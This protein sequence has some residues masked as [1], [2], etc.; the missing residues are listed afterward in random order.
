MS[1]NGRPPLSHYWTPGYWPIWLGIAFLRATCW[2]PY[3]TQIA[4]G[5]SIGRLAHRVAATRRAITRRNIEICFPGLDEKERNELALQHFESLGASLMEMALA[6][7][8]STE[9]L[10]SLVTV[11]GREHIHENTQDGHGVIMLSAHFTTVEITGRTVC[12]DTPPLDVVYR[13]F[14]NGLTTEFV[15]STRELYA[16]RT[17]D[18]NDIKSMVRSL[19]GGAMVWYA[20]DQSYNQKQ[21][22]LINFFGEPAMTNTATTTL[23]KLG[24]AK[25]LPYFTRRLPEGG[26]EV[27][28]LPPLDG[29]P[30][31]DPVADTQKYNDALE[32]YVRKCPEQYYW[33]H[34]KFKN[35]PAELPDA[36][37]NLDA[38]K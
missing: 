26:Y 38:L 23:A 18:K 19:R 22:A 10:D 12:V 24:R 29:V 32:A 14:R 34:R 5:K 21:S 25:V 31:D 30:S 8:A 17:I 1:A 7:W 16:R 35:R 6:R 13:K 27:R 9:K 33:I 2:L 28:I 37:A 3:A 36:Y 4:F 20:P 15:A 11:Y